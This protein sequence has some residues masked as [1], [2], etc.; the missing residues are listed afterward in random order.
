MKIILAII[1][2]CV[3]AI[4]V[5][6]ADERIFINA[7]ING[8][9]VRF[10]FDSGAG[11]PFLLYSTTA[12]KLGLKVTQPPTNYQP[13]PG[14]TAVGWT[15][16]YNLDLGITNVETSF[17]VVEAPEYLSSRWPEDGLLGW[18]AISNNIFSLD[19]ITHEINLLTNVPEGSAD[20]MKFRIQTIG[21]DL[22]LQLSDKGQRKIVILDTGSDDG[23]ELNPQG[24]REW[25]AA[26]TNQPATITAQVRAN[27]GF[28]VT[29]EM[30]ANKIVLGPVTLTDVPLIQ[31]DP[32]E[33][34]VFS[35]PQAQFEATLGFAALK[36]LDII[37]DGKHG[38]AYLRPKKTPPLLYEHNRLGAVFVP[39][40]LQ[41]EDLIAHVVDGSP[42]YEAGIRNDD[43]LLKIDELD[44]TK[45]RT[46]PN[47]LPLSRFWNSPAGTKLELTLKRGDKIFKT[48]AVLRNI[49]PPDSTK[50]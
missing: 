30:W 39:Q 18:P 8:K 14:A 17:G 21:G 25:N 47:V 9:S 48:T 1:L 33:I 4:A 35:S 46:D 28:L 27:L 20:W 19:C 38:I 16:L 22:T 10:A 32:S 34:N 42:A 12:Q 36:R 31:V 41:S 5:Y 37:I 7:K 26:H 29:E 45:W 40:N 3:Y 13:E 11:I 24:W 44:A 49:L 43:V 6:A 23:V 50:N 2:T 15:E